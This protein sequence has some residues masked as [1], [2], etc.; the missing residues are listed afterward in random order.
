VV[1]PF[2]LPLIS[3][4]LALSKKER[5]R[6]YMKNRNKEEKTKKGALSKKGEQTSISTHR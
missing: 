2:A 5:L 6:T 3:L 1:G 4:P